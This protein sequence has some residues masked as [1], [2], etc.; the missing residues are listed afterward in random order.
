MQIGRIREG[1]THACVPRAL[2]PL[3]QLTESSF[4]LFPQIGELLDLGLIESVDNW[5]LTR[6]DVYAL[7]LCGVSIWNITQFIMLNEST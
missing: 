5:V 3:S 7:D 1:V 2:V 6:D 4:L